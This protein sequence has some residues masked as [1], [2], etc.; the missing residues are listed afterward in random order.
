[1][2]LFKAYYR[3]RAGRKRRSERW[4]VEYRD[5][6]DKVRRVPAF[7]DKRASE[8]FGRNL[9]SLVALRSVRKRPDRELSRWIETLPAKLCRRLLALDLLDGERVASAKPLRDHL[10]DYKAALQDRGNTAKH[11]H[12]ARQRVR[13]VLDGIGAK[14]HSDLRAADVLR[15][16]AERRTAGLSVS[17][18]NHYLRAVKS[19]CH[20]LVQ[21]RR[22]GDNPLAHL[23]QQNAQSDRRHVRRALEA[24]ELRQLLAATR[25]EPERY[26]MD[27]TARTWLYRLACETGLR[28]NELRSL[29]AASFDLDGPEPNVTVAAGYSKRRRDDDQPL[30]PQTA[31]ELRAFL[32][33]KL[34]TARVFKVPH[35]TADMLRADLAAARAAWIAQ[36]GSDQER[37]ER[38][39]STFLAYEDAAG[40]VADFHALRHAFI[41]ALADA[42]VHPKQAQEL[43]RHSTITL[44]MDHYTH[45][46][47][48]KL[49]A[50]LDRLPDLSGPG[51]EQERQRATGTTDATA[52]ADSVLP[53]CLPIEG[54]KQLNPQHRDAVSENQTTVSIG[55]SNAPGRI[56]TSNPRI[57]SPMLYPIEPRAQE[58]I[59]P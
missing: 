14:F 7:T 27:G 24:D 55:E 57:R 16:L 11:A 2:R 32:A 42:G 44:T 15:Y 37:R 4:Y 41:T 51:P 19:F 21:E 12:M 8:H 28:A 34:P 3:D 13:A 6:R 10:D 36:A 25:T 35:R 56:R 58:P 22:A 49:A 20:W 59:G 5:H 1:M 50:D 43:A 30:R 26:G 18:T 17:S 40:N 39:D 29:T 54:S 31:A 9:E 38:E 53:V 48:G 46:R 52:R 23:K 47:R 33:G 45:T